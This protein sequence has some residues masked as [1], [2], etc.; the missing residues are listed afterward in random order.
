MSVAT[1]RGAATHCVSN[2]LGA[3]TT[4]VKGTLVRKTLLLIAVLFQFGCATRI[5]QK[6]ALKMQ[7]A[8]GT[9]STIEIA[10]CRPLFAW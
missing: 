2:P 5:C 1:A 10:V 8:D 7:W 6:K 9:S 3:V 4:L